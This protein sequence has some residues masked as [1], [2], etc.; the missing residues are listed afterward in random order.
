MAEDQGVTTTPQGQTLP[1]EPATTPET[2]VE[3]TEPQKPAE[4]A[5]TFTQDEL[6]AIVERRL[7]KERRKTQE[8]RN[9]LKFTEEF[10]LKGKSEEKKPEP[11]EPRREDFQDYETYLEA[12]AEWKAD[13]KVRAALAERDKAES[14]RKARESREKAE[15]EFHTRLRK[16]SKD[17]DDLEEVIDS[18]EAPMT[19]AM[20]D[21]IVYSELGPQVAY[22]LAKHTDE[23][24]RIAQLPP[25]VAAR[26]IGKLEA[27]I[28]SDPPTRTP[29][30]APDPVQ[31][32]G[33]RGASSTT[34]DPSPKDDLKTWMKKRNAQLR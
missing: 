23:A 4:P 9:R 12:K 13:Q 8:L 33:G 17:Y 15:R 1:Q 2:V 30:K 20:M 27:K 5:K 16:A 24:E 26:E 19:Q 34:P 7:A 32:V 22:Y 28:Q 14:E 10:A 18:S 11:G 29:S 31:P 25:V 3:G 21:A 6:D